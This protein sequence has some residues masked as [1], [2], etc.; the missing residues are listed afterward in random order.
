MG[1][2]VLLD[3][4]TIN[5]MAAGEVIE[6]PANVVK[7]L[8][9]NSI[10][11]GAKNIV[12]EVKNGGK[13]F[14]RIT[15]NGKGIAID[16]MTIAL[17]RHATSKIRQ[18][19]DLEKT[20]TMGFRGEALASIVSISKLTII[21]K[22][23]DMPMGMKLVAEGGNIISQDEVG[24]QNGTMMTV[25]N[26]FFNVPVRYKFLKNDATEFRY[27]KELVQ[28]I[29][30]ANLDVAIK[31]INDGKNVFQS[32]GNGNIEDIVYTL[33]GKEIKDNLIEVNYTDGEVKITGVI[34]NTLM[35]KDSRKNQILFLN[36]RNIKNQMLTNSADQAF[37]GGT[38]IGKYGFFILN[39]EMPAT[40]YDVNV[41]PTKME[42]RFK[43]EQSLYKIMYHAI[44]GSLLNKEFLGNNEIENNKEN[45]VE[46]ELKFLTNHYNMQPENLQDNKKNEINNLSQNTN[47][48]L[49]NTYNSENNNL[50]NKNTDIENSLNNKY[51]NINNLAIPNIE[52]SNSK[53]INISN[54]GNLD[55][56]NRD[57]IR[58]VNYK[59]CGIVFRT[60]IMIEIDNELYLVDQHAAHERV[61]YE[62]IKENY[63]NNIRNNSQLMLMPEIVNLTHR[64]M[65]FVQEN[66]KL[67]Q[68]YGFDIEI[69]GENS[70]KIN[71]IPDIEYKMKIDTKDVF[72][73]VL[74]EML[75]KERT[76]IKD[77]EERFIAT[78]AC[79]AAVK[80]NMD[81]EESEVHKLLDRLLKLKNPYT[82][83]HG[84]PTTIKLGQLKNGE[85][86]F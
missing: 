61:L 83:P 29:A 80:A 51:V 3:D 86:N 84:R 16:D 11:A 19:E 74:D 45:Y 26:L 17:E 63:K 13:T 39:M 21:S 2:I 79:K 31:L 50:N 35:A 65:G 66:I 78:V 53:F 40:Y 6:R 12:V 14:I 22:T 7:E 27:I 49:D 82:C 8:V 28:K 47:K 24:A 41:H 60:F 34:G 5:K 38:G 42:V 33:F 62:Q 37:K 73:D 18:I 58:D 59:Y 71:G 85:L 76:T 69:F 36:K 81:L 25:E 46:D 23:Q 52:Q 68:N 20:Y 70:I 9:E 15:D 4:L 56:I 44:K 75:T 1:N 77:I 32:T 57:R 64:E 10:D 48:S 67:F 54:N 43:D 55:L 72:M 30:L